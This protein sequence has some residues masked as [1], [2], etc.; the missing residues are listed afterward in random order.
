MEPAFVKHYAPNICLPLREGHNLEN[1][2]KFAQKL[3]G[4]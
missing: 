3:T 2:I 4:S 1:F